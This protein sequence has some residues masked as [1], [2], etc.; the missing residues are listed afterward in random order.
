[1]QHPEGG[2]YQEKTYELNERSF[3]T[4]TGKIEIYSEA[5]ERL[6]HSPLPTY[7]EPEKSPQGSSLGGVG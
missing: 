5:F 1:M 4:P 2:F 6:G 7:L 3:A